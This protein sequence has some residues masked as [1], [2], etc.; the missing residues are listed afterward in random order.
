MPKKEAGSGA[1]VMVFFLFALGEVRNY[2]TKNRRETA[3]GNV[4]ETARQKL[5][6]AWPSSA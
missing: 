3:D 2:S 5:R 1:R 6:N 4:A